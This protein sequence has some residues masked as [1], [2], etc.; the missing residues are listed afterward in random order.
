MTAAT[1]SHD[2]DKAE[3]WLSFFDLQ[4]IRRRGYGVEVVGTEKSR[5]RAMS[6]LMVETLEKMNSFI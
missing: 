5:R 3:E 2:L 4:L 1:V 6:S